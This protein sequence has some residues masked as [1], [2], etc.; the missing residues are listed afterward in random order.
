MSEEDT[1]AKPTTQT[2]ENV[3][4]SETGGDEGANIE[5]EN[6]TA[7]QPLFNLE[8]L[9]EVETKTLE[10]SEDVVY[11]VRAKM[12]RFDVEAKEWKERGFG[13]LKFLQNKEKKDKVRILMRRD[14]TLKICANHFILPGMNVKP[15]VGSDRSWVYNT[16]ADFYDDQANP[17][18][19]AV[20]F[21]NPEKASEFKA[22]FE[23]MVKQVEEARK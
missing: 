17:E 1:L 4:E 12:F 14:K 16:P 23:E 15:N 20:R 18:L 7:F 21:A 11:E 3:E 22:K 8:Q 10:E 5:E 9:P 2:T 13:Q 19:L 6:R